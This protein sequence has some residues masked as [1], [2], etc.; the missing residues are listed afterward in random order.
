MVVGNPHVCKVFDGVGKASLPKAHVHGA[1]GQS[2]AAIFFLLAT[3]E[4]EHE[5]VSEHVLH[6]RPSL[7]LRHFA[8]PRRVLGLD[9]PPT[10]VH[11]HPPPSLQPPPHLLPRRRIL[12][13]RQQA[14][15]AVEVHQDAGESVSAGAGFHRQRVADVDGEVLRVVP[16]EVG[17]PEV[18]PAD[19]HHRGVELPAVELGV[20]V[21]VED[22]AGGGAGAEAEDGDGA[23]GEERGEGGEDVEV[24]V[25]E[26][27]AEEG[28]AVDVA[29][30]VEE[31]EAGARGGAATLPAH[32]CG[33]G[34]T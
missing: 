2:Q 14:A 31:E 7:L 8:V 16:F 18:L 34:E 30:L 23:G 27:G 12:E 19:L 1:A 28:D 13:L 25:G 15:P 6:G 3:P 10:A 29:G 20:R 5:Q 32:V 4:V 11:H 22:D 26:S 33:C 17:E 21:E 9:A 24:G